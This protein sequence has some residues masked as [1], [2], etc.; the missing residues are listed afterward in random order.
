MLAIKEFYL[1]NHNI[2]LKKKQRRKKEKK[3]I[4]APKHHSEINFLLFVSVRGF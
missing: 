2:F 3:E 4:L 1:K